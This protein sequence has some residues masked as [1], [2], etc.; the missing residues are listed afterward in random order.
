RL[1]Y[2]IVAA[3][4]SEVGGG[5]RPQ[6]L[7]SG[8]HTSGPL[9]SEDDY[10]PR[11]YFGSNAPEYSVV[12]KE[13]GE[14][15]RKRD[16]PQETDSDQDTTYTFTGDGG[17]SIGGLFNRLAYAIQFGSTDLFLSQDVNSQSQILFDRD[18]VQ[19]VEKV[20]QYLSVD[21]TTYPTIVDEQVNMIVY[22]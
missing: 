17:P 15:D 10:E 4:A 12:R 22:A 7:L 20:A 5:G 6:F 18:P 3:D 8:I 19:R 2:C 9:A 1:V 21:N 16:R 11:I 14:P 13:E